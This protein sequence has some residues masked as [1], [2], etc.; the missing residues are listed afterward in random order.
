[1]LSM[2]MKFM[3]GGIGS[4]AA[5]LGLTASASWAAAMPP[6]AESQ[7]PA[8]ETRNNLKAEESEAVQPKQNTRIQDQ[9]PVLTAQHGLRELGKDFLLDQKQIWTSPTRLRFSDTEWLVP[10]SGITAGLFVT[11]RSFSNHLSHNPNTI[12]RYKPLS[13][14]G[15]A[16][17]IGAGGAMWALGHVSHNHHSFATPSLPPDPAS[18]TLISVERFN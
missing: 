14:G 18:Y 11:D 13:D 15:V 16:A 10:L 7:H 1:M 17:L 3:A 12:S 4:A 8:D 9:E 5:I 2:C 6:Q